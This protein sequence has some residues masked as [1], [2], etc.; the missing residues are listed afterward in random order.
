MANDL[1]SSKVHRR[2]GSLA[3]V[4]TKP[5]ILTS[6][7][8]TSAKLFISCLQQRRGAAG[9]GLSA[10]TKYLR[11]TTS[12]AAGNGLGINIKYLRR[13]TSCAKG[14]CLGATFNFQ[15]RTTSGAV[16]DGL[17]ATIK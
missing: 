16:G 12:S 5:V 14:N 17:D 9:N 15:R 11:R 6:F 3:T 8:C 7:R 10:T 13:T 1:N 4:Q 2:E